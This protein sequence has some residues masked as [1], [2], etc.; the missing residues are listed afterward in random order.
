[1]QVEVGDLLEPTPSQSPRAALRFGG[2]V[3][4][5]PKNLIQRPRSMIILS[6]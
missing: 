4:V 6:R 3:T 5:L 2:I 1:M